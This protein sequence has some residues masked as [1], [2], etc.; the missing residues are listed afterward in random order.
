MASPVQINNTSCPIP[1]K[2]PIP[3][4][5]ATNEASN[6]AP[7][8]TPNTLPPPNTDHTKI[9]P[10]NM[11]PPPANT[12]L[13]TST[14]KYENSIQ[15]ITV[16]VPATTDH[17]I[18]NQ[19]TPTPCISNLTVH[20]LP[21]SQAVTTTSIT[22]SSASSAVPSTS[23][24]PSSTTQTP[25]STTQ[26]TET[27][28]N[29]NS[30]QTTPL[31]SQSQSQS[32]TQPQTQ[33]IQ[34]QPN[35]NDKDS[36]RLKHRTNR[37]VSTPSHKLLALHHKTY[38]ELTESEIRK[39]LSDVPNELLIDC[40]IDSCIADEAVFDAFD[41]YALKDPT[42]V[43]IFI[44]G[45]NYDTTKDTLA[46]AFQRFGTVIDATVIYDK[47]NNRSKGY[48][49]ITFS[50]AVEA[51]A[52]CRQGQLEVD[53]RRTQISLAT[54]LRNK[55]FG[56][57][58]NRRSKEDND[59]DHREYRHR[60]NR[61]RSRSRSRSR[62]RDN[63]RHRPNDNKGNKRRNDRNNNR[64]M[65]NDRNNRNDRRG[66][67]GYTHRG[68]HS[69]NKRNGGYNMTHMAGRGG[70]MAHNASAMAHV[71]PSHHP[72]AM[73]AAA[74]AGITP[75]APFNYGYDTAAYV[76]AYNPA[77]YNPAAVASA[78]AASA[79]GVQQPPYSQSLY[80]QQ[81]SNYNPYFATK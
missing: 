5:T 42:K 17:T 56:D 40:L 37:H 54:P 8:T 67:G 64:F 20:P 66:R 65:R 34:H 1:M 81:Y 43:R 32:T 30:S 72:H 69:R 31:I 46:E 28:T 35:P 55:G 25:A 10:H 23:Q 21:T 62:D 24:T 50:T 80:A 70:Y 9:A 44:R 79:T 13:H 73:N 29:N 52:A 74:V 26:T 49:F 45:L 36:R 63:R 41:Q 18:K 2:P 53:N 6:L 7:N 19:S 16:T 77:S 47:S 71:H 59:R 27:S 14:V 78:A 48:G 68:A 11:H 12:L 38:E 3:T 60:G 4:T 39:Y 58:D 33:S 57:R 51:A 22:S 15:D 61:N 75:Y 76:A